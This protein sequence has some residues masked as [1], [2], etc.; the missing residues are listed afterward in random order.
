MLNPRIVHQTWNLGNE[1]RDP[2][3]EQFPGLRVTYNICWLDHSCIP[4]LLAISLLPLFEGSYYSG[5]THLEVMKMVENIFCVLDQ[6][7]MNQY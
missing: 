1:Q 5:S 6:V 3:I 4:I 7:P 2:R